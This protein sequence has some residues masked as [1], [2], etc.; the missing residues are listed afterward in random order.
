[1][2]NNGGR[3]A[4]LVGMISQAKANALSNETTTSSIQEGTNLYFTSA[5]A[6]SVINA[7]SPLAYNSST[8]T[9]SLTQDVNNRLVTD[10]EKNIWNNK[11]NSFVGLTQDVTVVTQTTPSVLTSVLHFTNGVLTSIT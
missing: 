9:V 1:M 4:T 10:A 5:R 6:R 8:G 3:D 7:T 11:A 2:M